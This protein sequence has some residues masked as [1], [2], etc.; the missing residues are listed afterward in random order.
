MALLA[1][2]LG[3]DAKPSL[4]IVR[5]AGIVA[6]PAFTV[7]TLTSVHYRK[8]ELPFGACIKL[9]ESA[10]SE[11]EPLLVVL[12]LKLCERI[13]ADLHLEFGSITGAKLDKLD[14]STV[15]G[16]AD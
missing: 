16:T 15:K 11:V 4:A 9:A 5:R 6:L 12:L 2:V 3:G 13:V 1:V 7:A 8:L 10:R 14:V